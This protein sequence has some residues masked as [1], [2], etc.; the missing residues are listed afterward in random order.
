MLKKNDY[1]KKNLKNNYHIFSCPI[2]KENMVLSDKSLICLNNHCFDISHKGCISLN[3]NSKARNEKI[4]DRVLFEN[5]TNFINGKFYNKLHQM[6]ADIINKKNNSSLIIDMGSGD[7]TH[8]N[9]IYKLLKNKNTYLLGIDISKEGV[10]YSSNY[11]SDNFIPVI[12]DLNNLPLQ[13]NSID[14]ILNILSPSNEKEMKRVLSKD[15]III[16]VTPKKEYLKELRESLNI[17]E[18]ENEDIINQ[19]ISRNYIIKEKYEITEVFQLDDKEFLNLIKMTPL[20]KNHD[21]YIKF[22]QI[23]IALNI[24]VLTPKE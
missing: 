20:A 19:N 10:E 6:I 22:E 23:T 8:D 2:C 4:Y 3:K 24:Y 9:K 21:K 17:K 11:V 14:V 5:R 15:G 7:G 13:N 12:A 18:Y 1:T 16:K